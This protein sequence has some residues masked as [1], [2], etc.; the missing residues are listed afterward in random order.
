MGLQTSLLKDSLK[1]SPPPVPFAS[2]AW[3][4]CHLPSPVFTWSVV[5]ENCTG[6]GK[7]SNKGGLKSPPEKCE[8]QKKLYSLPNPQF[9]FAR[10]A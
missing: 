9:Y 10:G 5:A 8:S 4:R 3:G 7:V 6:F 2:Y 1:K